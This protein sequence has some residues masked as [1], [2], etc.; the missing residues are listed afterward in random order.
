MSDCADL[1]RTLQPLPPS[2]QSVICALN[3]QAP[4]TGQQLRENTGLP[5]RTVYEA[6]RR[7]KEMGI[8]RER[9]SLRDTRQTYFWIAQ[10][11]T[12]QA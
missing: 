2:V 6:L 11:A 7:L 1:L 12:V 4:M 3:G 9:I 8:L 10:P 5:R